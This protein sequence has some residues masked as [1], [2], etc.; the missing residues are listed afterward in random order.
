M[1]KYLY[2]FK[3][4]FLNSLTYRF[5]TVVGMAFGNLRLI[6]TIVFWNLIY[7]GDAQKTLNGFT[8]Q[9]IVTYLIVIDVLGGLTFTLR[10]SGFNYSGMIKSGS[11]GPA[12]LKPQS[13]NASIFFRNFAEGVTGMLPQAAL[14]IAAMPFISR[15]MVWSVNWADAAFII[16]FLAA[17]A[18]SGHLLWSVLGYMAFWLEEADAVMWSFA[19]LFNFTMGFFIPLDFFPKWSVHILEMLPVSAWGYI[20][21]KIVIGLY[22]LSKQLYLLAAQLLWI[23]ALLLLNAAVWARGARRYSA[24]GG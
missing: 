19:V 20:Q 24:V 6:I 15:F 5:N 7:G 14:V 21:T 13:L 8:L 2:C 12:L 9:G 17:G 1:K 11:L 22:P 18:A 23:G 16:L 3:L 4:N 10:N